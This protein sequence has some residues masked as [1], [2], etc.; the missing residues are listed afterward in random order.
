ML[1]STSQWSELKTNQLILPFLETRASTAEFVRFLYTNEIDDA[2]LSFH[3]VLS[4]IM[5]SHMFLLDELFHLYVQSTIDLTLR[6]SILLVPRLTIHNALQVFDI[7]AI[8]QEYVDC[9]S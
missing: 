1:S 8:Y 7:A 9:R 2:A 6:C 4:M 3:D 5:L